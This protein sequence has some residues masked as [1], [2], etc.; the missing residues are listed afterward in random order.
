M[1]KK[2]FKLT[3]LLLM[4]LLGMGSAS[5]SITVS[6]GNY[7]T[8]TFEKNSADT[9]TVKLTKCSGGEWSG[10]YGHGGILLVDD[11]I[12][13]PETVEANGVQKTVLQIGDN[14]H[15]SVFENI[16][17]VVFPSTVKIIGKNGLSYAQ[18]H[19]S[20]MFQ[21]QGI[22]DFSKATELEA[23]ESDFQYSSETLVPIIENLTLK[24]GVELS[25]A[26]PYGNALNLSCDESSTFYDCVDGCL[27]KKGDRANLLTF[28]SVDEV[29]IPNTVI[30]LQ[31]DRAGGALEAAG[32]LGATKKTKVTFENPSSLESIKGLMNNCVL[33]SLPTTVK[34]VTNSNNRFGR[35][36][37]GTEFLSFTMPADLS[38]FSE[39]VFAGT[40]F[41]DVSW[42]ENPQL[43]KHLFAWS[44]FNKDLS[45]PE[46]VTSTRQAFY[47]ATFKGVLQLPESF[48][49]Q[50]DEFENCTFHNEV[51]MSAG[52][53]E[54]PNRCFNKCTFYK[55]FV[56]PEGME[57][58]NSCF[59]DCDFRSG[60]TLPSRLK[61]IESGAFG[62][63]QLNNSTLE[64]PAGVVVD[65]GAFTQCDI[66]KMI[67]DGDTFDGLGSA[68]Y[69]L[70]GSYF[71]NLGA[72][73]KVY[74]VKILDLG[75]SVPDQYSL[76]PFRIERLYVHGTTPPAVNG[77]LYYLVHQV[78]DHYTATLY[79]PKGCKEIYSNTSPW[80]Y[81]PNIVEFDE[82]QQCPFV[83]DLNGDGKVNVSDITT[84][85]NHILDESQQN[86]MLDDV[87]EDSK[88]NVSDVTTTVNKILG[89]K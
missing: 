68:P 15:S 87:N 71:D 48:T 73:R 57:T 81:F 63:S 38:G 5:A 80:R 88:V 65:K 59:V 28:L 79:V 83:G 85:I 31:H 36:F 89:V 47:G 11:V 43:H 30:T 75:T 46:G 76:S 8:L 7:T 60:V 14:T 66:Y 86:A 61:S 18:D 20:N 13:I 32:V 50:E 4:L 25:E 22:F 17:K 33:D 1:E 19:Y 41:N 58:I 78:A 27:F 34:Q 82:T 37:Y 10:D 40:T 56:L 51:V 24:H 9:N 26:F 77:E 45:L 84:L 29:V 67:W 44:T 6:V 16:N 55:R 64:I 74:S 35:E 21:K 42:G 70:D 53:K 12:E 69:L 3:S 72:I 49:L 23:I 54:F 2:L 52:V 39:V 62:H